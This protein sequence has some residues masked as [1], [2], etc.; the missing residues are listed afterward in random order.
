[1][2][3][4]WINLSIF[5]WSTTE[6][7]KLSIQCC[8]TS[9]WNCNVFSNFKDRVFVH[10]TIK[11]NNKGIISWILC[12]KDK[13]GIT[14]WR[15]CWSR[16]VSW[17]DCCD[18]WSW[19]RVNTIVSWT[20]ATSK[21]IVLTRTVRLPGFEFFETS[22]FTKLMIFT[23]INTS[24]QTQTILIYAPV[25]LQVTFPCLKLYQILMRQYIFYLTFADRVRT[26]VAT[27]K[28]IHFAWAI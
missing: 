9:I 7:P 5:C 21:A 11:I 16:R 23:I 2:P 12:A 10:I 27:I 1:M 24:A 19:S 6:I 25:P 20:R 4:F 26:V 15:W 8:C 3:K 17:R 14:I 13:N 28:A 18:I 22:Y